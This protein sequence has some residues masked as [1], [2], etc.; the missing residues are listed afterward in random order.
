MLAK[1]YRLTDEKDFKK[2]F[3]SSKPF[4]VGNL[5]LRC[6]PNKKAVSR[7]GFIISNKIDKRATKRNELKRKMRA[8]VFPLISQINPRHDIVLIVLKNFSYPYSYLDIEN[9][10]KEIFKKAKLLY[11]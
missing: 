11:D 10:I 9:Q 6:V 1:M 5:N 2:V 7:I 3:K 4:Y 8:V